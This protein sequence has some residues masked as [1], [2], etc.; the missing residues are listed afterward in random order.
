MS[1][2]IAQIVGSLE[3]GGMQRVSVD[4]ANELL[5]QGCQSHLI[6]TR[7][8][9]PL[10]TRLDPGVHYHVHLRKAR[11]DFKV[12]K[13]VADYLVE[14]HIDIVHS[15]HNSSHYFT[16]AA[17]LFIPSRKRPA[18]VCHAHHTPRNVRGTSLD[19]WTDRFLLRMGDL[20]IMASKAMQEYRQQALG[21]S[22]DR[23]VYFPNGIDMGAE[24]I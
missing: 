2:R 6:C 10:E 22:A 17:F 19:S 12:L 24:P 14:N 21:L 8:G 18:H 20:H 16:R 4:L 13:R 5:V 3:I 11:F 7:E 15:H 1:L 23:C 9:G